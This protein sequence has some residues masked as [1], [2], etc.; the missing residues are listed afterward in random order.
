VT[1]A[2]CQNH[3]DREAIGVCIKCR[4]RICSECVTKVDGINYCVTCLS[5]LAGHGR[6]ERSKRTWVLPR[7]LAPAVAMG[8]LVLLTL[9]AW[10]LV[11]LALAGG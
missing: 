7:P 5:T 2:V 4:S 6:K 1:S 3:L 9:M 11:E 8:W 10:G